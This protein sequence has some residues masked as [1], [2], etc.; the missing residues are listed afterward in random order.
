MMTTEELLTEL[1]RYGKLQP[2]EKFS[3]VTIHPLADETE[4]LERLNMKPEQC[5][6]CD[7]WWAI[8]DFM[9]LVEIFTYGTWIG[10][11]YI[12]GSS[13][14]QGHRF[15]IS[16]RKTPLTSSDVETVLSYLSEWVKQNAPL[17]RK[18]LRKYR[19]LTSEDI[20]V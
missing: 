8:E 12:Q 3:Y 1:H 14:V 13:G 10:V 17:M 6:L 20:L 11:R 16:T 15:Q 2:S 7:S 4:I 19:I 5:F 9:P 18:R